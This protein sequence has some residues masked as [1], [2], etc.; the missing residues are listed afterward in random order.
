MFVDVHS[1]KYKVYWKHEPDTTQCFI[2]DTDTGAYY[3]ALC[4]KHPVDQYVKEIGRKKSFKR[5]LERM[6]FDKE[7]RTKFWKNYFLR[8]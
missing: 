8:G 4:K 2:V 6:G 3:M 5:T 7:D 1:K